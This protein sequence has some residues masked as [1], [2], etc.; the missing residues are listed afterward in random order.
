MRI[1]AKKLKD[2]AEY[3]GDKFASEARKIHDGEADPL[4]AFLNN[5]GV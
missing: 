3:V 5:H 2:V 4:A 1:L